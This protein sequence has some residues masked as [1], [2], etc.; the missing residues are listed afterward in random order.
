MAVRL[1]AELAPQH[2]FESE[3][4]DATANPAGRRAMLFAAIVRA[5]SAGR[6]TVMLVT[7]ADLLDDVDGAPDLTWLPKTTPPSVRVVV[8]TSGERPVEAGRH[9]G[10]TVTTV[11]ALDAAERRDFIR[12]F[13]AR[14]AKSLDAHHEARLVGAASAGNALFLRTVLDELRQHGDHFTIGEVIDRYLAANTLDELLALVLERYERDFERDRPGLVRDAMR[15]LWAARR[16]LTEP[17]LLDCLGGVADGGAPV[18]HAVWSPL[19]LAAEAGLVTPRAGWSSPP[20]R[21]AA[22]WSADT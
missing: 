21:I 14:S 18:P 6:R 20:S 22:P 16:G 5:G 9:R 11:P 19:V 17:E 1:G 12:V 10:W 4:A 7:G 8:T 15:A 2:G 3:P 13:F